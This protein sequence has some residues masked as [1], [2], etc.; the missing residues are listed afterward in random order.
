MDC[1]SDA[2]VAEKKP[3]P[4]E[5]DMKGITEEEDT[6]YAKAFEKCLT[7]LAAEVYGIHEPI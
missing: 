1:I 5:S 7:E 6:L 3:H 2:S 4:A